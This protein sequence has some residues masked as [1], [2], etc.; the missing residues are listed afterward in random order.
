MPKFGAGARLFP[1]TQ[2]L[3]PVEKAARTKKRIRNP[4]GSY[5]SERSITV[6]TDRGWINLPTIINGVQLSREEAR[7][8]AL[9]TGNH[10]RYYNTVEEAVKAA[11]ERSRALGRAG[12]KYRGQ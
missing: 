11:G 12:R 6:N 1:P 4:D 5:S 3:M 7:K 8:R 9:K 10:S 2:G